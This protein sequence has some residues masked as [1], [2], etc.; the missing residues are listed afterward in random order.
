MSLTWDEIKGEARLRD[1]ITSEIEDILFNLEKLNKREISPT[2]LQFAYDQVNG[3]M[4][5]LKALNAAFRKKIVDNG[6][7]N[8]PSFK[9]DSK[10]ILRWQI[11]VYNRLKKLKPS[12]IQ[13]VPEERLSF[14]Q[15]ESLLSDTLYNLERTLQQHNDGRHTHLNLNKPHLKSGSKDYY[16]KFEKYQF[17][18]TVDKF[19][20]TFN[21]YIILIEK[22]KSA[23]EIDLLSSNEGTDSVM[24]HLTFKKFPQNIKNVMLTLSSTH[25]PTFSEL[26]TFVPKTVERLIKTGS[27]STDS[28]SCNVGLNIK[29]AK[30]TYDNSNK[31][32]LFCIEDKPQN[33]CTLFVNEF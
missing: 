32:C 18:V 27:N 16:L 17:N 33:C 6:L 14:N 30:L 1:V 3:L 4:I 15:N 11:D 29:G 8:D 5:D 20:E 25:Y 12:K 28:L 9:E 21:N 2:A 19:D 22:L 23:H 13:V 31:Y 24:A 26:K 7:L 10:E